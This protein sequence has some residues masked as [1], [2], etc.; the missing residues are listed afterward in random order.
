MASAWAEERPRAEEPCES[1]Q[2]LR[3]PWE[4]PH[5]NDSES[6]KATESDPLLKK[7]SEAD[8]PGFFESLDILHQHFGFELLSLL[9]VVQHL[10]KGFVHALLGQ[11]EPYLF[12][13]YQVP[14]PQMQIYGGIASLP[15][16]LKPMLGLLSDVAP[17]C[18]YHKAPYM[19]LTTLLGAM[20]L[21]Q[22]GVDPS[23]SMTVRGLVICLFV[24]S[25]Q[26]STC[27]LLS[28]AKYAEK[29]KENPKHGPALLTY[30]WFGMQVGGLVAVIASGFLIQDYGPRS[31]YLICVIPAAAVILP[32]SLGYMQEQRK[33]VA[34]VAES[35]RK[36]F[37]QWEA[38][39]LCFVISVGILCLL[40]CGIGTRGEPFINSTAAIG[41]GV[42][43]LASFSLF[44]SPMIAKFNAFA[45]IQTSLSLN[46]GGAAFY[47]FT[48]TPEQYP[49]G[50][51]FSEFFFNSV[52][53]TAGAICS[54][55]GIYLYQRYLSHWSYRSLLIFTNAIY[56]L[57]SCFDILLFTRMNVKLGIPDEAF[58]L[59][60]TALGSVI[61]QWKWMPG[62]VILS[63]MCPK[64]MEA[65]MYALLA[66]CHNLGNM[67]AASCG[68]YLLEL[69]D[70]RPS[71]APN[72]SKQFENL[73][74]VSAITTALPFI[75]IIL[76]FWLI[77]DARQDERLMP[78]D[79]CDATR[80]SLYRQ[81][82]RHE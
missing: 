4:V 17:I 39:L 61:N 45:F 55:L 75:V 8:N 29:V 14:A 16:A 72:E 9:F 42:V 58:V 33:S 81:W 20:A 11:A 35:R 41:V 25:L 28:E 50:P 47:F 63:H 82:T 10:L 2:A 31:P 38:C 59:S 12:R 7:V 70:C 26:I 15:W 36:V 66:G 40:V 54:L 32:V 60:C 46:L 30:V 73:W 13:L 27:D 3:K 48:D 74:I 80:G 22:I 19:L 6:G 18:G 57:L 76:L 67:V 23:S 69:L 56:A 21:L 62:V 79:Q 53:G 34:E 51:H 64:G 52:M 43:V 37:G 71:G 44:L 24:V 5:E 1:L 68:A 78:E 77:P 49:E 65:I